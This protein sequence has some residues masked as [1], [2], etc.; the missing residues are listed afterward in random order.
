[1]PGGDLA[2]LGRIDRQVKVRGFRIE[3]AEIEATLERHPAVRAAAVTA[4]RDPAGE[5]RLAAYVVPDGPPPAAG[6]LRRFAGETLPDHMI[7]AAFVTLAALPLTR[8][9]KLDRDAL[10]EPETERRETG[11]TLAPRNAREAALAEEWSTVLGIEG[12]GVDDNY[13]SLGGDSIKAIQVVSRLLRRGLKL[14]IRDL[15]RTPTIAAL[16]PLLIEAATAKTRRHPGGPAPL[17]PLQAR[18]LGQHRVDPA[19]FNYALLLRADHPLDPEAVAAAGNAL[20]RHHDALRLR[21]FRRDGVWMQEVT[22]PVPVV[23]TSV[24]LTGGANPAEDL[25]AH[26]ATE[27]RGL[28]L[29]AGRL[30]RLTLYRRDDAD[31][32]LLLVHHLAVDGISARILMEDFIQ[33]Y[34]AIRRGGAPELPAVGDDFLAWTT[35]LPSLDLAA[36]EA[37]WAPVE[38]APFGRLPETGAAERGRYRDARAVDVELDEGV[39]RALL[40]DANAAFGTTTEDLLLTALGRALQR[41]Q[42]AEASL[43]ALQ[44]HGREE[45]VPDL[46]LSRTLGWFTSLFPVRIELPA[47]RD[48][49]R[50]IRATKDMLRRIPGKGAGY[51]VLRHL[52][53]DMTCP[54]PQIIFNYLGGFQENPGNGFTL[55]IEPTGPSV[56]PDALRPFP[57]EVIG[58]ASGGRLALSLIHDSRLSDATV[59]ALADAFKQELVI[60]ADE[61]LRAAGPQVTPGDSTRTD[62]GLDERDEIIS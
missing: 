30:L 7:P 12:I 6:E 48:P 34:S 11:D 60:V 10:P 1:L 18:F 17:A 3:P 46:D 19:H 36:E 16:A 43:I 42:G 28:D 32:V 40:V 39:G 51:G 49:G 59:A 9:G 50:H 55:A 58:L 52:R 56:N 61:G 23:F 44:G 24:D 45:L 62:L 15:L 27:Q 20:L 21:F 31:R 29:A 54:N 35:A 22:P 57:L 5:T 4:R 33:A 41:R 38:T 25:A 26:A 8:N 53:N 47:D 13:F 14:E 37:W 2:Y